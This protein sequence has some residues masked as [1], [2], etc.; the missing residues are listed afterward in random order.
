MPD[1][2]ENQV[3]EELKSELEALVDGEGPFSDADESQLKRQEDIQLPSLD[4]PQAEGDADLS[5]SLLE[6][7]M[8]ALEQALTDDLVSI[9]QPA[10]L[11]DQNVEFGKTTSP[12]ASGT[13]ITITP[14]DQDKVVTGEDAVTVFTKADRTSITAAVASDA[15]LSWE[16][17][18]TRTDAGVAGVIVGGLGGG[19]A[20]TDLLVAVEAGQAAGYLGAVLKIQ[21]PGSVEDLSLTVDGADYTLNHTTAGAPC[22]CCSS[23]GTITWDANGHITS[24]C[25][26]A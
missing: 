5:L 6:S 9:D 3:P 4:D 20:S 16:R 10:L 1:T 15:L 17:F 26:P 24:V 18:D 13:T 23:V 19:G 14:C 2:S 7:R 21:A 11:P 25:P 12:F 22:I 8:A